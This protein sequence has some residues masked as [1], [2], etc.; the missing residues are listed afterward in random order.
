MK[1]K[2]SMEKIL[3]VD[4]DEYACRLYAEQFVRE[5]YSV[6][7]LYDGFRAIREIAVN[8]PDLL[9]VEA[10]LPGISGIE[11]LLKAKSSNPRLPVIIYTGYELYKNNYLAWIADEVLIKS[12][13]TDQLVTAVRKLLARSQEQ[14][15][16]CTG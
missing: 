15:F 13:K 3:I 14:W 16:G 4:G 1:E 9:I 12:G 6:T 7:C 8:P 2:D 5:G 10:V 11:L